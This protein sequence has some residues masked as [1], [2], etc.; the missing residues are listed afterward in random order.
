VFQKLEFYR[1]RCL[2]FKS[3]LAAA[4]QRLPSGRCDAAGF[5]GQDTGKDKNQLLEYVVYNLSHIDIKDLACLIYE[6]LKDS[7]IDAI[8]V[9]GACV[10]IYS[11]NRYQSHDLDFVT[12]EGFSTAQ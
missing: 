4:K 8:L 9:G 7:G 6:R 2:E 10:S 3:A 5:K 11:Q 12:H 1:G